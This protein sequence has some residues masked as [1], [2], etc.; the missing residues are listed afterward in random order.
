MKSLSASII[1]L[2]GTLCF[3]IGGKIQHGDTQLFVCT[4]GLLI[5]GAGLFGWFQMLRSPGPSS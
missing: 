4:V 1:V 3:A 5:A 2:A